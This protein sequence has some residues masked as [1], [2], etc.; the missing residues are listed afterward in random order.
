MSQLDELRARKDLPVVVADEKGLITEVN[1][2]FCEV[3]GWSRAEAIGRPL[4][5]IIPPDL[6]DAHHLGFSRF[7]VTGQTTILG[8]PLPLKAV[9]R[10][11][12]VF[13]AEHVIAGERRDGAWVF[14]ATIRPLGGA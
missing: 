10:D 6:R 12:T 3:F 4:S 14:A 9:R 8:K 7:L 1:D 11:G 5:S 13:E 2:L